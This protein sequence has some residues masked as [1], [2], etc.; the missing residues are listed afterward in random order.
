MTVQN[1]ENS[2][3]TVA[4]TIRS[5]APLIAQSL[6]KHIDGDRFTRL[7]LTTLRKTPQLQ[8]CDPQSFVG[9][10][11][12]ASALGLEPDTNGEAYLVPYGKECTL[13]I[14]YQGV[15]KLFWQHPMAARLSAEYVCERD[16][17]NFDKGLTPSL[18]HTP[19]TGDRGEVVAYYAIVGLTNG[20]TWFDVFTPEQIE[21]L[22]GKTR[23]GAIADPEHWMQRKTALKQVV[24]LAPKAT[25]LQQVNAVDEKPGTMQAAQQITRQEVPE[26]AP[27]PDGVNPYTGEV[28]EQPADQPAGE[29]R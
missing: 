6:P 20:A 13:I 10:L 4:D 7:A 23:K 19:A 11:L 21:K 17:F 29:S 15:A 12:T 14:G 1:R 18:H 25:Q 16:E 8:A 5:F 24:K 2:K 26:L 27:V 3:P 22:R 9:A 28:I